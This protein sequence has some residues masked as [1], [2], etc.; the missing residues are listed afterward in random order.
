MY[1][2][3]PPQT[4]LSLS[5]ILKGTYLNNVTA[6]PP[7]V[8]MWVSTPSKGAISQ[9]GSLDKKAKK[10]KKKSTSEVELI[11]RYAER[12]MIWLS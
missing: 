10:K 6:T 8:T 4:V 2:D 5:E 12:R 3:D 7:H 9:Y 1:W 11:F